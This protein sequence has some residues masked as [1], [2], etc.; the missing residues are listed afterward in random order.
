MKKITISHKFSPS[1]HGGSVHTFEF[2]R[3]DVTTEKDVICESPEEW[4]PEWKYAYEAPGRVAGYH[5]M[6]TAEGKEREVF[7]DYVECPVCGNKVV[8][9]Y[10]KG[11]IVG[12]YT[13]EDLR[14]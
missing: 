6:Y 14:M 12:T 10:R 13:A 5:R 7:T 4:S 1:Y 11:E 3:E 8:A 2:S 9:G